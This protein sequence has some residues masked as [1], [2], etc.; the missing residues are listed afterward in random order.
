MFG[1]ELSKE[2]A[3]RH[4]FVENESELYKFRNSKYVQSIVGGYIPA[5]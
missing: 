3:A 4:I 2:L 5:S 1:V